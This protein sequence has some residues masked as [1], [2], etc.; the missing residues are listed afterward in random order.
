M[1][2]GALVAALLTL[3]GASPLG[4]SVQVDRLDVQVNQPFNITVTVT[5]DGQANIQ[6]LELPDTGTLQQLGNSRSEGTTVNLTAGGASYRRTIRIVMSVS[7]PAPGTYKVGAARVVAGKDKAQSDPLTIRAGGAPAAPGNAN[8]AVPEEDAPAPGPQ[9]GGVRATPQMLRQGL[10]ATLEA[11]RTEVILG[12]QVTLTVRIFS[13]TDLNDIDTLKLPRLD[14]FWTEE[15]ENPRRIAPTMAVVEGQR[16]QA[17]LLR[18]LAVFPTRAGTFDLPAVDAT[19]VTGGSFFSAG[20][21]MQVQSL[22]LTLTVNPLPAQ[23][24]PPG[25]NPGNVGLFTLRA[26][27]DRNRVPLNQPVTLTV[28]IEG[29]GNLKQAAVP[30]LGD[31]ADFRVYD[32][33]PTESV[34]IRQD[35]FV[36]FKQLEYLLQPR[37]AGTFTLPALSF[38]FFDPDARAYRTLHAPTLS[39][40]VG[41]RANDAQG[42]TTA[43]ANAANLLTVQARPLHPVRGQGGFPLLRDSPL[44]GALV[45]SPALGAWSALAA[46]ALVRRRRARLTADRSVHA[47]NATRALQD[48]V[49][50]GAGPDGVSRALQ[51]YL[52]ARLAA[53][54]QGLTRD[55]LRALCGR[56]G[57]SA[58]DAQ[59]LVRLLD[60]LDAAR[61][62]PAGM[63][64]TG[65]LAEEAV[66]VVRGMDATAG[67]A[68]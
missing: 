52:D 46:G 49:R 41:D 47:R 15:L 43:P 40:T 21:R 44:L 24:Q 53:G 5:S 56:S 51:A 25:F 32:P 33:T 60:Q 27:V 2:N 4:L 29:S 38:H 35:R 57:V 26:S 8:P 3:A 18:R 12:E 1:V 28:R 58:E 50:A 55:E 68:S 66:A 34:E 67:A 6:D 9:S 65:A 10:F 20:R 64:P 19:V 14:N 63:A 23:G 54:A 11:D 17:Y 62:A 45:A 39:I 7:A 61:Y 59:R 48:A 42:S 30:R 13:R 36:G 37:K 22:P 16:Y 31:T